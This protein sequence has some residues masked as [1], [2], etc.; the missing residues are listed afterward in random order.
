MPKW[1]ATYD[2]SAPQDPL[3][4]RSW[5]ERDTCPYGEWFSPST[6]GSNGLKVAFLLCYCSHISPK[7]DKEHRRRL[8]DFSGKLRSQQGSD[9]IKPKTLLYLFH[10]PVEHLRD[11]E[12]D[13]F[14]T[15]NVQHIHLLG[16]GREKDYRQKDDFRTL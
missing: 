5:L 2:F 13:G 8:L 6:S 7:I 10:C 3:S 1:Q 15:L 11:D 4:K 9:S 14:Q 16:V 12:A